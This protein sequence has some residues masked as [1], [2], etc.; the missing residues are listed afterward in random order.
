MAAGVNQKLKMLY[1][2]RILS[3]ETD[4]EH[5]RSAQEIIRRREDCGVNVDRRTL[6]KD[7]DEL[8]RFGLEILREKVGRNTLYHLNTRSFELPE[9]KL[10]VDSVQS[11]RFMT[12]KKSRQLIKKL[13]S[14]A[15]V[16]EA[17]YLHR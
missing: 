16:H 7:L 3:E 5:G 14:L 12:E 4:T 9:L 11:A 8:D 6:Y 13:E 17:R 10:L 1:L 15:S 2:Q